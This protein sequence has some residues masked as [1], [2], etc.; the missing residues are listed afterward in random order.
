MEHLLKK[1]PVVKTLI[2]LTFTKPSGGK[3]GSKGGSKGCRRGKGQMVEDGTDT[4]PTTVFTMATPMKDALDMGITLAPSI[5]KAFFSMAT[6]RCITG[7]DWQTLSALVAAPAVEDITSDSV[8]FSPMDEVDDD[9][10]PME[11][12][13]HH[14]SIPKL[15]TAKI[16]TSVDAEDMACNVVAEVMKSF[17]LDQ[18]VDT[19]AITGVVALLDA[20]VHLSIKRQLDT[21]MTLVNLKDA[22]RVKDA[23]DRI[24]NTST[25]VYRIFNLMPGGQ[26]IKTNASLFTEAAMHEEAMAAKLARLVVTS[27][28]TY[29]GGSITIMSDPF[30]LSKMVA[31]DK[32]AHS[33]HDTMGKVNQQTKTEKASAIESLQAMSEKASGRCI[34]FVFQGRGVRG[35]GLSVSS[36]GRSL[37]CHATHHA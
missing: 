7:K 3:G 24:N 20:N 30:D 21:I 1:L 13:V 4:E 18:D 36:T 27:L 25:T 11:W 19:V 2:N 17:L 8:P 10:S 29:P 32:I 35:G 33:F 14:T 6:N 31:M 9:A 34:V 28:R 37:H 16:I 15:I 26:L 12:V 22:D 23:L 5:H